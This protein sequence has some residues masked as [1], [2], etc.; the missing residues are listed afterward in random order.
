MKPRSSLIS[1]CSCACLLQVQEL[2]RET[3]SLGQTID[4]LHNQNSKLQDDIKVRT[5]SECVCVC[6]GVREKKGE[7]GKTKHLHEEILEA[8]FFPLFPLSLSL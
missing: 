5:V 6:E 1:L 7:R 4:K 8:N 3:C 2:E